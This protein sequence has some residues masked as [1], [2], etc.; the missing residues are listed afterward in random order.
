MDTYAKVS[1]ETLLNTLRK[2]RIY[3]VHPTRPKTRTVDEIEMLC[4]IADDIALY[5]RLYKNEQLENTLEYLR[6]LS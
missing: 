4:S 2:P 5:L 6:H 1:S 3:L